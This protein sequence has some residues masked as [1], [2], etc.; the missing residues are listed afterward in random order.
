METK[1]LIT[2]ELADGYSVDEILLDFAKAF[3]SVLLLKLCTKLDYLGIRNKLLNWCK[4]FLSGR[5]QRVII[6]EV[7]SEWEEIES[8]VPQ[9]PI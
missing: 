4:S 6:G 8:G 5:F 3:D 2:K 1:D 7:I 9:G